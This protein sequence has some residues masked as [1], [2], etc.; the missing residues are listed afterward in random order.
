M[1]GFTF[2]QPGYFP[3]F[4][5]LPLIQTVQSGYIDV[6]VWP[7]FYKQIVVDWS[8]PSHWGACK[9]DVYRSEDATGPWEKMTTAPIT[10]NFFK[11][12][13]LKDFSKLMSG[14]YIVECELP[15]GRRIQSIPR[16]WEPVRKGW[17]ELRAKEIERRN[18]LLLTKFTGIQSVIFRRRHFG[19]RC[20]ECWDFN[21][22]KV[23]KDHCKT[24]F[25]TSFEG[26][27]FNGYETLFQYDTP[28]NEAVLE[29]RGHLEIN[30]MSAW[31][32]SYPRIEE[33]DLILR[34]PDW[35]MF[36]VDDATATTLQTV[37]IR[38]VV[39]LTE[40]SKDGIEYI[41]SRQYM[42]AAYR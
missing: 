18:A 27:Y 4:H 35:K 34:L 24:C 14:W 32:V 15:D 5:R 29:E 23:T 21:T 20:T 17:V 30:Q 40:L 10:N 8:I 42:P 3:A 12:L 39:Q 7:N 36:R 1:F 33:L 9:F 2:H 38:Q 16:T 11:D 25:G 41:L 6:T 22:E 28:K 37:P 19:K 26:G 31:T 13:D